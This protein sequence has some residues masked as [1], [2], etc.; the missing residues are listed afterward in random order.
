[1]S[2]K[3]IAF[4]Q[5]RNELSKGNLHKW[6][7]N[8]DFCDKI[9]IYDNNSTDGSLE[10]YAQ[11]PKC[12]VVRSSVN[13]FEYELI[14]KRVLLKKLL[15]EH[16]DT[17]WICWTDV[18]TLLDARLVANNAEVLKYWLGKAQSN[19]VDGIK[20]GHYN[21]WKSETHYRVDNSYHCFHEWGRIPLWRNNGR[22]EFPPIQGLHQSQEPKGLDTIVR[23]DYNL[24]H[25]GFAS[26]SQIRERYEVYKSKGQAGPDL[27]RLIDESTLWLEPIPKEVYNNVRTQ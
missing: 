10:V 9:Y 4:T 13:N 6:L 16:P 17:D 15:H 8:V 12:V 18:D 11:N 20:L 19:G 2:S 25:R 7:E 14:C 27:D 3:I 26:E 21:L 23:I 22:L 24:V 1:M 5:A